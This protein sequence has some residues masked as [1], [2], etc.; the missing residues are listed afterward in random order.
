MRIVD[1]NALER[2]DDAIEF[3]N[4]FD[5]TDAH[6]VHSAARKA[7]AYKNGTNHS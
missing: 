4:A 3:G 5:G 7:Q 2:R 1:A 6:P